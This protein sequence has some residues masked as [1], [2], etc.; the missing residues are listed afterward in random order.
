MLNFKF[1]TLQRPCFCNLLFFFLQWCPFGRVVPGVVQAMLL[2]SFAD[3]TKAQKELGWKA[4]LG[5]DQGTLDTLWTSPCVIIDWIN[6]AKAL[7][8]PGAGRAATLMDS[9]RTREF[10]MMYDKSLL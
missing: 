5:V 7:P 3:A 9:A 2:R 6:Y 1:E 4:E 8:I 10:F